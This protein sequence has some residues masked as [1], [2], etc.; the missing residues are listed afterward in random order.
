MVSCHLVLLCLCSGLDCRQA[1]V[2]QV[3]SFPG[4]GCPQAAVLQGRPSSGTV[5]P[6]VMVPHG[7]PCSGVGHLWTAVLHCCPSLGIGD[8]QPQS[9]R[10]VPALA[11]VTLCDQH[12][13]V[14]G[15]LPSY[16]HLVTSGHYKQV[17]QMG[18]LT[19]TWS[20]L[21]TRLKPDK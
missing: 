3:C 2:P 6:Q 12:M 19:V 4:M 10:S 13:V 21:A 14:R 1:A 5:H 7:L 11:C 18:R 9:L 17:L 8:P 20:W 16:L 15:L